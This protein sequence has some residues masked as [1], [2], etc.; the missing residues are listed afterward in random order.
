VSKTSWKLRTMRL[1]AAE[2]LQTS[3]SI[4]A[5]ARKL[6]V[7]TSTLSRAIRDGRLPAPGRPRRNPRSTPPTPVEFPAGTP[8]DPA[9]SFA[10]WAHGLYQ[11]SHAESELV[12]LAQSALDIARDLTLPASV[13]LQGMTQYRSCLKDLQLPEVPD[14]AETETAP[15]RYPRPV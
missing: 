5:A 4:G 1:E 2:A 14:H 12:D 10:E 8:A 6:G 7:H 3:P 15:R 11:F 9:S 13:R